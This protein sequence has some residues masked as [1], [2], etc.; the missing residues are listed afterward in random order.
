MAMDYSRYPANWKEISY[1][2]RFERAA[3]KCE[4]CQAPHGA[5]IIRS[6]ANPYQYVV[7]DQDGDY[8]WP[9]GESVEYLPSEYEDNFK[10]VKVILTVHHIGIDYADGTTGNPHDKMDCRPDNL[11][12]LCQRCHLLADRDIHMEK[13]NET[14][15]KKRRDKIRATG[16]KELFT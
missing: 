3:G 9:N 5:Y 2:I 15:H 1:G 16:Q 8:T 12:A 14:R 7:M 13:A 6:L 11:I 4:Q 10:T